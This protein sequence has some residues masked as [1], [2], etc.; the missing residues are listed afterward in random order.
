[1]EQFL[2][3]LPEDIRVFVRERSPGSSEEAAKLADDY[4]QARKEEL[5]S[6]DGNKR[7]DKRC[8]RCGKTGHLIKDCRIPLSKLPREQEQP[9]L[10]VKWPLKNG[11]EYQ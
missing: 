4:L 8:L 5:V 10:L 7:G 1:M 2:K 3:T 11:L 9:G 6:H